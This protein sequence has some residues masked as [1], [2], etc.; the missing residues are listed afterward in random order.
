M[1]W[2]SGGTMVENCGW[3]AVPECQNPV[4]ENGEYCPECERYI[5][6]TLFVLTELG[7][8]RQKEAAAAGRTR[9]SIAD[10]R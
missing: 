7:L 10:L 6:L 1:V 2:I 5:R 4:A 3:C 9:R 8:V